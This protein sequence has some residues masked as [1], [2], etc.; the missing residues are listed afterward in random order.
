MW[1]Y[2]KESGKDFSIPSLFFTQKDF[3]VRISGF[4]KYI[5]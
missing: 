5:A 1:K 2:K 3:I 4:L